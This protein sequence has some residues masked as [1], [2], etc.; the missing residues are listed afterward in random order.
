M[1]KIL[2]IVHNLKYGGIQ[3]ITVELARYYSS[4]GDDV[5][6]LCLEEGKDIEIDFDCSIH[7]IDIKNLF[8]KRPWLLVYYSIYKLLLKSV[9]RNCD[10]IFTRPIYEPLVKDVIFNIELNGKVDAIFVRGARSIK[11]TWWLNRREVVTSFHLPYKIK[12]GS[13][14]I[15]KYVYRK[16]AYRTLNNKNIFAVSKFIMAGIDHICDYH[17]VAPRKQN[18]VYNPVDVDRIR[19]MS[20]MPIKFEVNDNYILGVGRLTRQ[21]RFDLL[22]KAFSKSDIEG[23][24][25][26]IIGEGNQKESLAKLVQELDISDKVIFAGFQGNPYPAFKNA[27][28]FVLSSDTEGFGNVILESMAC[29]TPVISTKC[30]PPEEFMLGELANGLVPVN[31]VDMLANKIKEVYYSPIEINAEYLDDFSFD[32]IS[33]EQLELIY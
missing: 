23:C 4:L 6:I 31:D 1:K 28:L 9:M 11:R 17:K 18:V 27:K 14:F 21:K 22:I 29:S 16:I 3:K 2:L 24:N 7:T 33:K 25:L 32:I 12:K 26:V 30:G 5:H 13:S 19:D 8:I 15:S 10:V 20:K